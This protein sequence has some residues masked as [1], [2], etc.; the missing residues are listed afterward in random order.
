M[1]THA[2]MNSP[3]Y[4]WQQVLLLDRG[5]YSSRQPW[6]ADWIVSQVTFSFVYVVLLF[7]VNI[8]FDFIPLLYLYFWP[9]KNPQTLWSHF[10]FVVLWMFELPSLNRILTNKM[11]KCLLARFQRRN[12]CLHHERKLL[13]LRFCKALL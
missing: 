9:L 7:F 12:L 5:Q 2:Y 11:L 1:I 6:Q 13:V 4:K 3:S 8:F 10:L